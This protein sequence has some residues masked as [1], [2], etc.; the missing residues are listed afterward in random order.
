MQ[1]NIRGTLEMTS[2]LKEARQADCMCRCAEMLAVGTPDDK[3]IRK[4][5]LYD[6]KT[7]K[8]SVTQH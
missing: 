3:K 7:I 4:W 6:L 2:G 1:L 5:S 8:G